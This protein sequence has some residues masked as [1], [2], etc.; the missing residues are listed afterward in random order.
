MSATLKELRD[1]IIIDSNIAGDPRFPITRL[2]RILNLA[3]RYVQTELNG[4]GMKKWED[5]TLI[6]KDDLETEPFAGKPVTIIPLSGSALSRMLESPASVLFI[7][8]NSAS[9]TGIGYEVKPEKFA[10]QIHN[11]YLQP[12]ELKPVFMRLANKLWVSPA[13]ALS[14][15]VF[16]YRGVSDLAADTDL[17]EIPV[18]FEEFLIKKGVLEVQAIL[19]LLEEKEVKARSLE[20]EIASAYEKFLGKQREQGRTD[21]NRNQRLQ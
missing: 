17:S 6:I 20:R 10:E 9:G 21:I 18:E 13:N 4:L 11:H 14:I 2:N 8:A 3:Q 12:T 5:A 1:Q 15:R 7:E 19:G 16:Y